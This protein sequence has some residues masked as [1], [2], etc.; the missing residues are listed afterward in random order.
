MFR[1]PKNVL[2]K[3]LM[4]VAPHLKH[5]DISEEL[6]R[7]H[8][9]SS[10]LD[11]A[12]IWCDLQHTGDEE[13]KPLLDEKEDCERGF[14]HFMKAM[15][16]LWAHPKNAS[17][18]RTRFRC[19]EK[20]SR[21]KDVWCWVKKIAALKG[22]KIV[23]QETMNKAGEWTFVATVDGVDFKTNEK[24]T[25]RHNMDTKKCSQKFKSCAKKHLICLSVDKSKCVFLSE[26]FDGA[27]LDINV[28]L[29]SGIMDLLR[30]NQLVIGD[31]G[32]KFKEETNPNEFAVLALPNLGIDSKELHNFK[33]RARCRHETF[34]GRIKNFN[35]LSNRFHHGWDLH[36][37]A[38]TAVC[39]IVQCQMDNGAK[40]FDV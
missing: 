19:C 15:F 3:G 7:D 38:V 9:G 34:N 21:G 35:I 36:E 26:P 29:Q 23:W 1:S 17:M 32:F 8:C 27:V 14:N 10:P 25:E 5:K 30:P 4:C 20:C 11:I 33:S 16:F 28:H 6:F 2:E 40:L 31:K 24:P 18:L 12:T 13:G 37:F 22:K 39:V